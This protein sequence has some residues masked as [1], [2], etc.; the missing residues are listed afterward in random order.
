MKRLELYG[1]LEQIHKAEEINLYR[2]P[3]GLFSQK[4][5]LTVV[6][7]EA[8]KIRETISDFLLWHAKEGI[9]GRRSGDVNR[10]IERYLEER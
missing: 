9:E 1:N 8:D 3:A 5:V 7:V 10:D 6:D 2:N 4:T